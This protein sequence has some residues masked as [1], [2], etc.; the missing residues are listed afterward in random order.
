MRVATFDRIEPAMPTQLPANISQTCSQRTALVLLVLLVPFTF[1][2]G[3]ATI[4]LV[5]AILSP[6]P[7]ATLFSQ[8]LL[9]AEIATAFAVVAFLV[10]LPI[11]RLLD[12]L[13][14]TRAVSIEDAGVTVTDNGYFITE[15]WFEP[16]TAFVGVAPHMRATLGATRHEIVLVHP[17]RG[18][19]VLLSVAAKA[20]PAELDRIAHMLG[21]PVVAASELYRFRNRA[22]G[23][24]TARLP[25]PS[26]A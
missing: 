15:T 18:K 1:A 4:S 8:P 24:S 19:S 16:L 11:K 13:L 9:A 21:Q 17:K 2:A 23:F 5:V 25:D 3:L 12:R 20:S 26:H 7:R 6:E 10:A 22:P 14:T